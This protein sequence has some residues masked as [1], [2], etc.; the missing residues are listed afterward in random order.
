VDSDVDERRV[1]FGRDPPALGAL[2]AARTRSICAS[3]ARTSAAVGV[4]RACRDFTTRATTPNAAT[5]AMTASAFRSAGVEGMRRIF[6]RT[7]AGA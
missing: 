6:R 3:S 1:D 2:R 4:G 5:A 7:P